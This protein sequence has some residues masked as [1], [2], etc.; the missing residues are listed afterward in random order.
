MVLWASIQVKMTAK[1]TAMPGM[2]KTLA[3]GS[4]EVLGCPSASGAIAPI[5]TPA[6][7]ATA[8]SPEKDHRQSNVEPSQDPRG[9]PRAN[10]TGAPTET[11]ARDSPAREGGLI[12]RP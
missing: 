10:P 8:V 9:V 6:I 11:I 3:R 7:T 4:R 1:I 12:F 5:I 2:R